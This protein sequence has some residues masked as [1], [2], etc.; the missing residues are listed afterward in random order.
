VKIKDILE[1]YPA[2]DVNLIDLNVEITNITDNSQQVAAGSIFVAV[3]GEK[4]NGIDFIETALKNGAAAAVVPKEYI[5]KLPYQNL[6]YV[7]N[8]RD[9]LARAIFY[10]NAE[11]I[12]EN[13]LTV[14]G[15]SG[16]T[17]ISFF[18]SQFLKHLHIKNM[19]IGTMGT[20]IGDRQID[21]GLTNPPANALVEYFKTAAANNIKYVITETSSHGLAQHRTDGIKFKVAGWTNLTQDHLDYHKS[22][23][24]YFL[25][26][27]RLYTSDLSAAAVINADDEYGAK[28]SQM[29]CKAGKSV[30]EYGF[31]GADIKIIAIHKED[32]F[33]TVQILY[34]NKE[35]EFSINLMGEF[36]VYNILCAMGMLLSQGFSMQDL[37]KIAPSVKR[38]RGRLELVPQQKIN[39]KIFVDYAH[40]P[41]AL[42]K[43]LKTL[44]KEAHKK[45]FVLFGCGGD[46]DKVKR[47]IMGKIASE[48]ADTVY[49]TDDNPR[50]ENAGDIR[51]EVE[52]GII[53]KEGLAV[54]NIDGR[55]AAIAK[56]LQDLQEGDILLVAG[57]GHED[58]Q[59]IGDKKHHFNDSET[60]LEILN[61]VK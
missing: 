31:K 24:E 22:M 28:L 57:K 58:Y 4:F 48:L 8:T 29:A 45:L 15:T 21:E 10:L 6:I 61:A 3:A 17:S 39:A 20:Y 9:F 12:P 26:K 40:K 27:A 46:R 42:E 1:F 2:I 32:T 47:P 41:D 54:Y 50:F 35:Y 52:K 60:I 7:E 33:Q 55:A 30:I 49:I 13:I 11:Y 34:Q 51:N 59:I 37:I 23:E 43:V 53:N 38:V 25:A 16:K 56:A 19:V 36:Q 5:N 44:K 14:S 18:V